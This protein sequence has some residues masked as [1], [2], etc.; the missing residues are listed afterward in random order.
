M[1]SNDASQSLIEIGIT[2]TVSP[3]IYGVALGADQVGSGKPE[4]T[5]IYTIA[6]T[7]TSPDVADNFDLSISSAWSAYLPNESIENLPSGEFTTFTVEITVHPGA[8]VGAQDIATVT[9]TSRHDSGA[10]DNILLT[11]TALMHMQLIYKYRRRR[12]VIREIRLFTRS[13]LQIL[14]QIRS[15]HL[16]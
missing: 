13:I 8:V 5:I 16:I 9:A 11:S 3:A 15:I 7:N 14:L 12:P 1:T 6:I 4:Q 10:N 2:V